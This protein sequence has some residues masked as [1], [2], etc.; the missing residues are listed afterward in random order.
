MHP[1]EGDAS[2]VGLRLDQIDA[3][4]AVSACRAAVE[5]SPRDGRAWWRLA[6]A[7]RAALH[8]GSIEQSVA[9]PAF[10]EALKRAAE[11]GD[12][13]GRVEYTL[14]LWDGP[15]DPQHLLAKYDSL[16]SAFA[17][18][19]SA[20]PLEAFH[21]AVL[22]TAIAELRGTTD[23]DAENIAAFE[24]AARGASWFA[25]Y[26]AQQEERL[27]TCK[28]HPLVCLTAAG[29]IYDSADVKAVLDII[30]ERIVD[31]YKE[32]DRQIA[33]TKG[34]ADERE[35]AANAVRHIGMSNQSLLNI[36]FT[37]GTESQRA[38]AADL[39]TANRE[40]QAYGERQVAALVTESER[41]QKEARDASNRAL[42]SIGALIFTALWNADDPGTA[43]DA[44]YWRQREKVEEQS[45][46]FS[47][48]LRKQ[49]VAGLPITAE[50]NSI[51]AS[52]LDAC[53]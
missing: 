22:R 38:A 45:R 36:A 49:Q 27:D 47:C 23:P 25:F 24:G 1:M 4:G 7:Y 37:E 53:R 2:R 14:A 30:A 8:Y 35:L 43:N 11:L 20:S 39:V 6:R 51:Y 16:D 44:E 34:K 52:V 21:I 50:S 3:P 12:I 28:R 41:K 46:R 18:L 10:A 17:S 48:D 42:A 15:G 26:H 19:R 29:A 9:L 33:S 31:L 13:P 32:T 40:L 5:R